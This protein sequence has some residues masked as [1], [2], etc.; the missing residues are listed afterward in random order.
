MNFSQYPL[1]TQNF[2]IILQSYAFDSDFLSLSFQSG[3]P[4]TLITNSQ[5]GT[6]SIKLNSLWTYNFYTGYVMNL[7]SPTTTDPSRQYSTA[8]INL[9][10][11]R[12][13]FGNGFNSILLAFFYN[14]YWFVGI[15]LRLAVPVTVFLIIVGC[16]FWADI[17][18]RVDVTLMM[19]LVVAALYVGKNP[20]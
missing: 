19:I 5:I 15:L 13:D 1:D 18:K 16:S 7:A 3:T 20:N 12:Q 8:F 6:A 2:S 14:I 4:V 10:F 9:S 11:S 17:E